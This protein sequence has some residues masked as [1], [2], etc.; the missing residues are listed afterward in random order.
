MSFH[1]KAMILCAAIFAFVCGARLEPANAQ[2]AGGFDGTWEGTFTQQPVPGLRKKIYPPQT[3]R[4]MVQGDSVRMFISRNGT[5]SEI[6][7]GGFHFSQSNTNALVSS[8]D[9]GSDS[10]GPWVE[11]ESWLLLRT[12]PDTLSVLFAGGVENP[13][14]KDPELLHFF[15]VSTG[16]FHR[17]P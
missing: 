12:D 17:V 5:F 16:A 13:T 2:T 7:P 10:D 1:W 3:W 15:S 9:S 14:A 8:V 6:K 4:M 11:T